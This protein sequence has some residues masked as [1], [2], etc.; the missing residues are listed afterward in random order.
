MVQMAK[1]TDRETRF[2]LPVELRDDDE[3]KQIQVEG[4]AAVFDEVADIGGWF[5]E[6]IAP[7]A[8][9]DVLGVDD[10]PFL[11]NHAGLPLA[12]TG[13]ETLTLSVDQR[14]LKISAGLE[15]ED[16][17]VQS[18]V[19][20]MKRGDLSKMSF[21]FSVD[22][23]EIDDTGDVPLRTIKKFKRLYDVAIVTDPAYDGTDIGL[24]SIEQHRNEIKTGNHEAAKRR[25]AR[26]LRLAKASGR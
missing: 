23:E 2:A 21:A 1:T 24:R 7:G 18:I 11:I 26:K 16:P 20:K 17:D 10:V 6:R 12:R 25:M 19:H 4:Y 3:G 22:I 8:F 14:G 9:D 13:S 5:Q 15:P